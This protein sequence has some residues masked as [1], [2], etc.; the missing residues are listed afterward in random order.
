MQNQKDPR[1]NFDPGS[2]FDLGL[3]FVPGSNLKYVGRVYTFKK[4]PGSNNNPGS[5]NSHVAKFCSCK[6]KN[7]ITQGQI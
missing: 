1:S 2:N 6:C 4:D 3:F 5:K 7:E